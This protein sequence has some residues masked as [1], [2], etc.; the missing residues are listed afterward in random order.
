M[1]E[2]LADGLAL[3]CALAVLVGGLFAHWDFSTALLGSLAAALGGML[4][5]LLIRQLRPGKGS[6]KKDA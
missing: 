3:L 4:A 2:R 6:G 5:G 1:H